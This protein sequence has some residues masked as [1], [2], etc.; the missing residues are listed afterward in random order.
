MKNY[1]TIKQKIKNKCANA[2]FWLAKKG[3]VSQTSFA[4]FLDPYKLGSKNVKV[5]LKMKD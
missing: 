1:K 5:L 2:L 4:S 3:Y